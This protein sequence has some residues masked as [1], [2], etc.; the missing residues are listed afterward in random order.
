MSLIRQ[1][2]DIRERRS[3]VGDIDVPGEGC[4]AASYTGPSMVGAL[5]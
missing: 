1:M 2:S 3:L 5:A 4:S